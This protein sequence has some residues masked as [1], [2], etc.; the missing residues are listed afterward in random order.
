M[1]FICN[2][3]KQNISNQT[4]VVSAVDQGY[5]CDGCLEQWRVETS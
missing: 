1:E 3:C 4:E 5:I 2:E